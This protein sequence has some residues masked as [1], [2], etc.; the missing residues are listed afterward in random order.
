MI[1]KPGDFFGKTALISAK[2]SKILGRELKSKKTVEK[3][4]RMCYHVRPFG[5][6][7]LTERP[8][9]DGR[10]KFRENTYE[11]Q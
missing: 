6:D 3:L 8:S 7:L 2:F 1:L 9:G 4:E 11:W 5:E 10:N